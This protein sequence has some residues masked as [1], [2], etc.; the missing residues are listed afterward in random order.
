MISLN[1]IIIK[2][3]LFPDNTSQVWHVPVEAFKAT[4]GDVIWDF[5]HEGEF[6]QLAQLKT[7]LDH[8]GINANLVMKYLPYGRQDK[9]VSNDAT[10]GLRTFASLL[11]GLSFQQVGVIDPHSD[12]VEIIKNCTVIHPYTAIKVAVDLTETE[13]VCYPDKGAVK[14]YTKLH[15]HPFVYGDKVRNQDTGK[16]ESM[17]LIG[18]VKGKNVLI[19]D[20]ICDGGGTFCWMASLLYDAGAK[21]VNLYTSHGIF[22]KG[23]KPLRAAKIERI[24]TKDGEISEHQGNICYEK[25]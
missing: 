22:S 9:Q 10:F 15:Y 13:L 5:E 20:D 19:I 12:V 16:I 2:P 23:L 21:E 3:T 17:K 4:S 7:L 8:K 6:M 14:K 25:I 11:N 24:F 18:D 1:G